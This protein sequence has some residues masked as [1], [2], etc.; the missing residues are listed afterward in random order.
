MIFNRDCKQKYHDVEPILDQWRS[1]SGQLC[2]AALLY[3]TGKVIGAQF[4]RNMKRTRR[5][6]R[7]RRGARWW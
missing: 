2:Y 7:I 6:Y 1:K 3:Y 5:I 4:Q